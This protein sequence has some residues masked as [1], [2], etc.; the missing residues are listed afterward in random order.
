[1]LSFNIYLKRFI[2]ECKSN[3]NNLSPSSRNVGRLNKFPSNNF[4]PNK[5]LLKAHI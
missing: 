2:N 3:F 4:P 5:K 1:M